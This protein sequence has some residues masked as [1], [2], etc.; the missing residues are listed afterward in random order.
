M[1]NCRGIHVIA[2]FQ[3]TISIIQIHRYEENYRVPLAVFSN[4]TVGFIGWII[5]QKSTADSYF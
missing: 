4:K 2:Y 1:K 5:E 3:S